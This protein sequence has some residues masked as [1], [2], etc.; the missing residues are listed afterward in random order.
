MTWNNARHRTLALLAGLAVAAGGVSLAATAAADVAPEPTYAVE[1]SA[2]EVRQGGTVEVTVTASDVVDLYA[3]DLVL[4]VDPK[5]LAYVPQSA[6]SSTSGTTYGEASR[7]TVRVL[8]TKLGS[9]PAVSGD[10]T[11]TLTFRAVGAGEAVVDA[12]S[13]GSVSTDLQETA[14]EELG[15]VAVTVSRGRG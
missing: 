14:A 12:V 3:Y 15:S 7:G 10:L 5:V 13:F 11:T 1:V 6:T 9:S 2:G 8:H 4:A